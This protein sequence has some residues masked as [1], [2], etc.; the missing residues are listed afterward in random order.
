MLHLIL[1]A[2]DACAQARYMR[3]QFN[4]SVTLSV[5]PCVSVTL[6]VCVKTDEPIEL[7]FETDATYHHHH[8]HY[9][10]NVVV[11]PSLERGDWWLVARF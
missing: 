9:D 8:R 4:Q 1:L 5:C 6:L 2:H 7:V 11:Y 10:S 3:Q